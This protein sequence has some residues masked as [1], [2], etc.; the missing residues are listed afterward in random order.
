MNSIFTKIF[1]GKTRV[2]QGLVQGLR[3]PSDI[4]PS[5]IALNPSF[6]SGYKAVGDV[7]VTVR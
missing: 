2:L 3:R 1:T 6:A 7:W 5:T 4:R